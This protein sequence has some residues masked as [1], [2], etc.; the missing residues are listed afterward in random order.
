MAWHAQLDLAYSNTGTL[1]E[2]RTGLHFL[3]QGPLRVL[4]S[5]YP[6]GNRVCHNVIVHPPSGIVGGDVLDISVRLAA[7]THALITTPGATR[8]YKSSDA[9]GTQ[10]VHAHLAAGARLEWL[11]LEAIAY[12]GCNAI[13]RAVFELDSGAEMIGWDITA[14]GLPHAGEPF[15]RG[16]LNQH[17]EL[18]GLWLERARI[19]ASDTRLM[20]S[21][22]GLAGMRCMGTL[23]FA[24]GEVITRERREALL[25]AV[26][27][28]LGGSALAATAGATAPNPRMVVVRTLSP[29]VEPAMHTLRACWASLRSVAW[30]MKDT[31]P[32]IWS[33]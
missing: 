11:P 25:E 17:I 12:N 15:V 21:P 29:V 16:V 10:Q 5:L 6:E 28:V 7:N 14:L 23:F 26:R 1:E 2:P 9:P 32:R 22:L 33:M 4:Q 19:D 27:A 31:P 18:P 8:F 24:S 3:H 20:D 13:N 30:G